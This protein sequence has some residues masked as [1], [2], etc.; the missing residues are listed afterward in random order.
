MKKLYGCFDGKA[1]FVYYQD[2][3][4]NYCF[5]DNAVDAALTA[6]ID[7]ERVV[8]D[9]HAGWVYDDGSGLPW[10]DKQKAED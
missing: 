2:D 1:G 10:E 9:D 4:G 8:W 5:A 6:P 3:S 7:P